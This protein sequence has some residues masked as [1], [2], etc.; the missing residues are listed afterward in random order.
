MLLPV[1]GR[2]RSHARETVCLNNIRQVAVGVL[3]YADENEDRLPPTI[4]GTNTETMGV[5]NYWSQGWAGLP[6]MTNTFLPNGKYFPADLLLC[7]LAPAIVPNFPTQYVTVDTNNA[8]YCN[9]E[10][11]WNWDGLAGGYTPPQRVGA[12]GSSVLLADWV[13]YAT[14]DCGMGSLRFQ[15]THPTDGAVALTPTNGAWWWKFVGGPNDLPNVREGFGYVDG[16]AQS[17]HFR[18]LEGL[19]MPNACTAG[20]LTFLPADR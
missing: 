7:P 10:M 18:E 1:L 3:M 5:R 13:S 16:H 6:W 20:F 17:W 8:L 2:A 19:S 4:V 12:K 14:N 15:L 11:F 9:Y